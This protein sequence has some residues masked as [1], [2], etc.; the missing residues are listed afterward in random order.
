MKILRI[1]L[2]CIGLLL[3]CTSQANAMTFKEIMEGMDIIETNGTCTI[4]QK[5]LSCDIGKKNGKE[6]F[7]VYGEDNQ[8]NLVIRREDDR[9]IWTTSSEI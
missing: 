7:I 2:L 8:P 4:M 9:V 1:S 5:R 3:G 6:Y